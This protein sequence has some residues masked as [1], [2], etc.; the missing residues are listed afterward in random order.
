MASSGEWRRE[1]DASTGRAYFWHPTTGEARWTLDDTES[2]RFDQ[3]TRASDPAK[4][5]LHYQNR[6]KKAVRLVKFPRIEKFRRKIEKYRALAAPPRLPRQPRRI[7]RCNTSRF[8]GVHWSSSE[9]KWKA[10]VWVRTAEGRKKTSIGTYDDEEQAALAYNAYVRRHGLGNKINPVDANGKLVPKAKPKSRFWGVSWAADRSKWR[11]RYR[12][13]S[14]PPKNVG[15]G[16]FSDDEVAALEYNKAVRDNGL[17]SIRNVNRVDA[18]GR[19]LP[20]DED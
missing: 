8:V 3:A 9:G 19:P 18:S 15:V 6:L 13:G 1:T 11:A 14:T 4:G 17:E 12:D 2:I 5:L 7:S 20:K 16:Y 10:N